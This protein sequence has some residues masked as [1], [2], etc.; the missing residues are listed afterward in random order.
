MKDAANLISEPAML[1]DRYINQGL[2]LRDERMIE[3]P[4]E[5]AASI[6]VNYFLCHSMSNQRGLAYDNQ[7]NAL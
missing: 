4:G 1:L 2:S 3:Q 5:R 6:S 7:T